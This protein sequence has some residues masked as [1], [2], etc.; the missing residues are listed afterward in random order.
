MKDLVDALHRHLFDPATLVGALVWGVV[1]LL[2][3]ILLAAL[4]R[5]T[6]RRVEPR[7]SDV[8]GLRFI[9]AF[10]QAL[11]YLLGLILYAHLVPELR[12]MGTALL[13]GV[14]VVSVILG[15]AAQ[16]TLGNLI[17]GLSLVLYRPISVGDTVQL[18]SPKGLLTATVEV[19]ALG[20][21]ILRDTDMQEVIVPNSVMVN[22]VVI[23]I[24]TRLSPPASGSS[25]SPE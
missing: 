10:A 19:V 4:I 16:N 2:L 6:T 5:R 12:S 25:I 1:F 8:T 22:S 13:A 15:L 7:L 11:A 23:R 3:A 17:A 18:G 14:S 21:T 24:G 20:Y 9:S